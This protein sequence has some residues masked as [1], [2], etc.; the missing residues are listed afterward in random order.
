MIRLCFLAGVDPDWTTH[1]KE[2]ALLLAARQGQHDSIVALIN[3]RADIDFTTN[4]GY[5]PL[6]E[7]RTIQSSSKISLDK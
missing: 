7:G 2:T 6:W 5:T 3:A 1:A 4:E